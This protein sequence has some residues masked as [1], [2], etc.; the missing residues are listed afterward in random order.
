MWVVSDVLADDRWQLPVPASRL[1]LASPCTGKH[2]D[3]Y[4]L[5]T[6]RRAKKNMFV[7]IL[8]ARRSTPRI[9]KERRRWSQALLN[10][11]KMGHLGQGMT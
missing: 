2:W 7:Y 4:K 11:L 1:G 8:S 3:G 9:P 5:F 6:K 10:E